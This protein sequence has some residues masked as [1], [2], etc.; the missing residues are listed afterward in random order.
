M[1]NLQ[2]IHQRV[3]ETWGVSKN[4]A[5]KRYQRMKQALEVRF[6]SRQG[7]LAESEQEDDTEDELKQEENT[8]A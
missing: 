4:A 8:T 7:D 3:A 5:S 2:G 6:T 1:M